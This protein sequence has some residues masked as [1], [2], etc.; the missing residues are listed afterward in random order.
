MSVCEEKRLMSDVLPQIRSTLVYET[1]SL[2]GT[3][4]SQI[5]LGWIA[6]EPQGSPCLLLQC[7]ND[8]H[9]NFYM[10]FGMEFWSLCCVASTLLPELA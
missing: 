10:S 7:R 1:G 2:I 9:F 8:G 3:S 6:G 4:G 5:R